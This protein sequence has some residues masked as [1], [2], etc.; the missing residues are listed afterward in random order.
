MTKSTPDV[1]RGRMIL[2]AIVVGLLAAALVSSTAVA[3]KGGGGGKRTPSGGT[4]SVTLVA[5]TNGNGAP[6]WGERVTWD[7]SKTT[8]TNPYVTTTCT[9]GG[10]NVLTTWAGYYPGYLWPG[11]QTITL[12]SDVWLGGPATC[13]GV[14]Y[15]TSTT[16]TFSVGG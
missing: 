7:V 15:G 3:G 5:D 6:D 8:V 2:N 11:A 16:L 14:L 13:T 10:T 9:Q 1:R 12:R 4:L